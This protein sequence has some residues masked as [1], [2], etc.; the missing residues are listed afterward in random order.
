MVIFGGATFKEKWAP[1]PLSDT[2]PSFHFLRFLLRRNLKNDQTLT[3]FFGQTPKMAD[4]W[5]QKVA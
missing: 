2:Y 3:T 5:L 4:F 1:D